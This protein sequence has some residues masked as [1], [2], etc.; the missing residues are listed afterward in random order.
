MGRK[1]TIDS[2]TLMNK[3][4]EIIEARWLFGIGL[5]KIKVIVHP[6][7]IIHSMVEFVDGSIKAQMGL[8]DMR[9]PIQYALGYP[10]R[11]SNTHPRL[12]FEKYNQLT[13]E[14]PDMENFPC[15]GLAYESGKRGGNASCVM[16]AANEVAVAAYLEESIRFVQ[17]PEIIEKTMEK[18]AFL[19][20][21]SA[22]QYYQ[23]DLEAR[24]LAREITKNLI[25]KN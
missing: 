23:T 4:L 6:Q 13:F 16:N 22:E 15:L 5:G 2:A 11:L 14:Q 21:C 10:Q 18:A 25:W 1:I 19:Q 20:N 8:P 17:I 3:G 24:L 9:L 7:S 12:S